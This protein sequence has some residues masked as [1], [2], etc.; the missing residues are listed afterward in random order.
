[1]PNSTIWIKICGL[2]TRDAVD[3]AV[4]AGVNAVGFVFAPSTRQVNALQAIELTRNVPNTVQRVAV[5]QHPAQ[6]LVDEVCGLFK[7][8]LLQTD[9]E[10]LHGLNIPASVRVLPVVRAGRNLPS[11]L[12]SRILFE[13][14]VSGIGE[15]ADWTR[16]RELAKQTQLILAGGLNPQNVVTAIASVR[17]FGVDVSTGVE[18][19]PGVKDLRKIAEFVTAVRGA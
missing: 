9:C 17:P 10:D 14:P 2:T 1:V 7:P 4:S 5:M 3:A 13:G 11:P 12:P 16:A 8:D 18:R 19:S 6:L 15:T